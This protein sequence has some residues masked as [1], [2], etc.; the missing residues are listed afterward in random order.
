MK[1]I[2]YKQ[3]QAQTDFRGMKCKFCKKTLHLQKEIQG[4]DGA[5]RVYDCDICRND[6]GYALA[7]WYDSK[8][9]IQIEMELHEDCPD[10]LTTYL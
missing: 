1:I 10:I 4:A 3:P 6:K 5:C 9:F 7:N 2:E 8:K